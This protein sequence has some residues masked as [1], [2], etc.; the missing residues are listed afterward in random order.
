V[1]DR[2]SPVTDRRPNDPYRHIPSFSTVKS[3]VIVDREP[4]GE[5]VVEVWDRTELEEP[6]GVSE[7]PTTSPA[8]L[9]H[10]KEL[11]AC[12]CGGTVAWGDRFK[13]TNPICLSCGKP[14]TTV[15]PM[16]VE[17]E[18]PECG[19]PCP[20]GQGCC[21][22]CVQAENRRITIGEGKGHI[23]P[24]CSALRGWSKWRHRT[25]PDS[26]PGTR[27]CPECD[28]A[29]IPREATPEEYGMALNGWTLEQL[30]GGEMIVKNETFNQF[31]Q[32]DEE[33]EDFVPSELPEPKGKRHMFDSQA[34]VMQFYKTFGQWETHELVL[35]LGLDGRYAVD[36]EPTQP[37]TEAEEVP[38]E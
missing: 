26:P 4:D 20:A 13:Q 24:S 36:A 28:V 33:T 22:D 11:P 23:C 15:E 30:E 19:D 34:G 27:L 6:A 10:D 12:K 31:F 32:I 21:D 16:A 1:T 9:P 3:T 2:R 5:N 38:G 37:A 29:V 35:R 14:P 25:I 7:E 8:T 17:G 18:C